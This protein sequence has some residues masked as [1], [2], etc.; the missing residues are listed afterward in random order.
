MWKQFDRRKAA[1][2]PYWAHPS[3]ASVRS[4]TKG[5][6][7]PEDAIKVSAYVHRDTHMAV[8]IVANIDTVGYSIRL[9]PALQALGLPGH[10]KEYS[11]ID[12]ILHGNYHYPAVGDELRL[13]LYPQRW[14]AVWLRK[15]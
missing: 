15:R 11:C 12:P 8:L 6:S 9:G 5:V 4:D 2:M 7:V 13:D 10:M 1:F 3:L 14:R